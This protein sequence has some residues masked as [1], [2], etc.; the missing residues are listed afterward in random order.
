[1]AALYFVNAKDMHDEYPDTFDAPS[2][3][4]LRKLKAGDFVKVCANGIER[5]WVIVTAVEGRTVTGIVN[6]DLVYEDD[7]G[8]ECDDEIRFHRDCI[9]QIEVAQ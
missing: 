1:M 7:H 4:Q 3:Y 6:N 8:L 9:Y 5:F 2:D